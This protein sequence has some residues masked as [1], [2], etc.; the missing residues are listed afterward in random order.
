MENIVVSRQREE[1]G[2]LNGEK[3]LVMRALAR[4]HESD[5]DALQQDVDATAQQI[6]DILRDMV[7]KEE[8]EV[9]PAQRAKGIRSTR[10]TLSLNGWAEYLQAPR[11]DLRAARVRI[12]SEKEPKPIAFA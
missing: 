2:N 12:A 7:S 11:L 6:H 1:L 9:T 10:F 8:V 5:E 4:L 3:F